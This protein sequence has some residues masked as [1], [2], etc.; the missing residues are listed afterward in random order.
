MSDFD[1]HHIWLGIPPREQP[2]NH[3]RLLG[4]DL[5][6]ENTEAIEAAADRQMMML[7]TF[8]TGKHS[9]DSQRLLAEVAAARLCL[10]SDRRR[11][12]Y[13]ERLLGE[14]ERQESER[15]V[16]ESSAAV[17]KSIS[18]TEIGA[19]TSSAGESVV[20]QPSETHSVPKSDA[21]GIRGVMETV[22]TPVVAMPAR[23]V[24]TPMNV[25]V[26]SAGESA[27]L[28]DLLG[29]GT[30]SKTR[31]GK[32]S[33]SGETKEIGKPRMVGSAKRPS[34]IGFLAAVLVVIFLMA[35]M[36]YTVFLIFQV[37]TD[38]ITPP[39]TDEVVSVTEV[40]EPTEPAE[41]P[42]SPERHN[43]S[44]LPKTDE[45]VEIGSPAKSAGPSRSAKLPKTDGASPQKRPS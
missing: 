26:R 13:D 16:A 5:F 35:G 38:D 34:W 27:L 8:Q 20:V 33:G 2:P 40:V 45:P 31:L 42:G 43:L 25:A 22:L 6:E 29:I 36:A 32:S 23:T 3:Y 44:K 1:P 37:L 18:E 19:K 30:S 15:R 7:R 39:T 10:L 11:A 14:I 9:A 17:R 12:A 24:V 28:G 41:V 4:L 21:P